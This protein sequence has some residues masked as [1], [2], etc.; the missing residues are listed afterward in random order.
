MKVEIGG[1]CTGFAG[2][3]IDEPD[4]EIIQ[5]N[6]GYQ[7][8]ATVIGTTLSVVPSPRYDAGLYMDNTSTTNH[9]EINNTF[10]IDD[11]ILTI[12]F[13]VRA[14]KTKSQVLFASTKLTIGILNSM[15]YVKTVSSPGYIID[16]FVTDEWNYIAVVRNNT[17]YTIYVNG[18]LISSTGA[19]NYY[20]HNGDKWWLLNRNS[21]SS[22]AGV[23][24]ISDF[25]IYITAL[26]DAQIKELY[27]TSVGIDANGNIYAREVIE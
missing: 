14:T 10:T 17:E 19:S 24:S 18:Q 8:N 6:S 13:W 2:S 9:I 11:N 23:A 16:N 15:L 20:I 26:T 4:F 22:Y 7:N 12:S 1:S 25:R 21:N 3:L 5:D 27:D